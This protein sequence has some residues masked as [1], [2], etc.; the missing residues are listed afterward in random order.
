MNPTPLSTEKASSSA[1]VRL[2]EVA[3]HNALSLFV[4]F[5]SAML[6][7][8][9][10]QGI[11]NTI[12]I[13]KLQRK[14]PPTLVLEA[15]GR[16]GR[17]VA[18]PANYR[19]AENIKYFVQSTLE[20]LMSWSGTVPDPQNPALTIPDPGIVISTNKRHQRI[21]TPTWAAGFA[22]S[23]DFRARFL[24]ELAAIIPE[25]VFSQQQTTVLSVQHI[26]EPE[27]IEPGSWRVEFIAYLVTTSSRDRI[28]TPLAFNKEIFVRAVPP[29][30][31]P[32]PQNASALQRTVTEIRRG[33]EIYQIADL[34]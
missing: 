11:V 28:G 29:S 15:S 17:A 20:L 22:L 19:T 32:L 8:V 1:P 7:L 4:L 25:R 9:F 34:N 33:L 24:E 3:R 30:L 10:V 14:P 6:L 26:S 18:H 16:A 23:E 31:N 21:T 2:L 12:A 27:L 5:S 13:G